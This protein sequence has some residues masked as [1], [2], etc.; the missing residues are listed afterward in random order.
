MIE[1]TCGICDKKKVQKSAKTNPQNK[2]ATGKKR[3][4]EAN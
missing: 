1:E 3:S 4:V 2:K